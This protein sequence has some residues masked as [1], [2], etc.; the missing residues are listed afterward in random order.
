MRVKQFDE[1]SGP[2]GSH[3]KRRELGRSRTGRGGFL[4]LSNS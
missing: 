3:R 1:S 4:D 2:G